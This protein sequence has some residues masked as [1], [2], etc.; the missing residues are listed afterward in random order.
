MRRVVDFIF[1]F[2]F[3]VSFTACGGGGGSVATTD[4]PTTVTLN[5]IAVDNYISGATVCI[6]TNKDNICN[7]GERQ[8]T[9]A[10]DGT[11]SFLNVI[12]TDDMII[13]AYGG[14]DS[15]TGENFPY[16]IKNI[17][18][19]K[20]STNKVVLSSLNT[21]IT[22]YKFE[23]NSTL[24]DAKI[25]VVNFLGSNSANIEVANVIA[26][27]IA[28]KTSQNDEFL[29]SLK[30]FQMVAV[31]ND[32]NNSVS[33]AVSFRA[34]A[35]T[36]GTNSSLRDT[37]SSIT[38]TRDGVAKTILDTIYKPVFLR[39]TSNITQYFNP[40]FPALNSTFS[41]FEVYDPKDN[42]ITYTLATNILDNNIFNINPSTGVLSFKILPTTIINPTDN[43]GDGI[44]DI[45]VSISNSLTTIIKS[46]K[47][48]VK[49]SGKTIVPILLNTN[50]SIED[51]L[52]IGSI[53]GSI[54]LSSSGVDDSII[55][56]EKVN[57]NNYFDINW[58]TGNIYKTAALDVANNDNNISILIIRAKNSAG[59]SDEKNATITIYDVGDLNST[60]TIVNE[61]FDTVYESN[62]SQL[63]GTVTI[64]STGGHLVTDFNITSGTGLNKFDINGSGVI[65][66]IHGVNFDYESQSNYT[67]GVKAKNANGWGNEATITVNI[68]DVNEAPTYPS[69]IND[70]NISYGTNTTLSFA[71]TDGDANANQTIDINA[72][73]TDTSKVTIGS[74]T[75]SLT[76]S[77]TITLTLNGVQVGSSLITVNV[78]DSGGIANSGDDT[79]S[80]SFTAF[81]RGNGNKI[82]EDNNVSNPTTQVNFDGRV[83]DWNATKQWYADNT[84][85]TILMPIKI[86]NSADELA[87]GVYNGN[88]L[89][90][91]ADGHYV[92]A[93]AN[94][95]TDTGKTGQYTIGTPFV[96]ASGGTTTANNN[97]F[98]HDPVHYAFVS[99]VI[100]ADANGYLP[101]TYSQWVTDNDCSTYGSG[102]KIPSIQYMTN[103][104][105]VPIDED[106]NGYIPA[107]IGHVDADIIS[108]TSY[109]FLRS[110]S[111]FS[112]VTTAGTVK[113]SRCIYEK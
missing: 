97:N 102:W 2:V 104:L 9:T 17:A 27:V 58:T 103:R 36:I 48:E 112:K 43:N 73:S 68:L 109:W 53:I 16:I 38:V 99:K 54:Q 67:L 83:Y 106:F 39:D 3:S 70:V 59:W 29:K 84:N 80:F 44:Y 76:N 10:N 86:I 52:T 91:I 107:Y 51:N 13:I 105:T 57:T 34:I 75:S 65:R 63:V 49:Q 35:N 33:S 47:V 111:G 71:L 1:V 46:V 85:N 78:K 94:L 108:S 60:A 22:D 96:T 62:I 82:Y 4:N 19:N 61:T 101:K 56:Y 14:L 37:N 15:E 24:D 69:I 72:T 93:K 77:G 40:N 100:R 12:P 42:N 87:Y 55:K 23:T 64:S 66:T 7:N 28:N 74:I 113:Q 32:V 89:T 25:A 26:D 50:I 18:T 81:V 79:S 8:T 45:N 90:K 31:I 110:L 21:L 5:G 92:V 6:D 88:N 95:I 20:D 11:F 30:I 98:Q 41:F